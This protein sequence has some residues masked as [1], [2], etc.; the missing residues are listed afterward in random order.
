M[1]SERRKSGLREMSSLVIHR[2]VFEG[3]DEGS[4]DWALKRVFHFYTESAHL[5]KSMKIDSDQICLLK[6]IVSCASW[7][8]VTAQA[9]LQMRRQELTQTTP[10]QPVD[11]EAV[12]YKVA[13]ECPKGYV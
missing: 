7:S 3:I 12:Y 9:K 13:G 11:D 6:S 10:D 4:L 2:F 1:L 8:Y 5:R